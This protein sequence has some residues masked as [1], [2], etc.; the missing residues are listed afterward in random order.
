MALHQAGFRCPE[1]GQL[2][3]HVDGDPNRSA[4]GRQR[5]IQALPDPPVGVGRETMSPG[6]VVFLDRP[7]QAQSSFLDEVQKI[8]A[9]ALIALGQVDH[10]TQIGGDH[11]ILGAFSATNHSFLFIAVLTGGSFPSSQLASLGDANHRLNLPPQHEFL[12]WSEKLVAANFT[13]KS[14][15]G[16][17]HFSW[18]FELNLEPMCF[19]SWGVIKTAELT[20]RP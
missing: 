3:I 2:F 17:H 8:E 9:F 4:L 1:F 18:T 19:L 5:S 14:T 16:T 20:F 7:R 11:L 10:Q 13:E 6:W 15:Q 12:L